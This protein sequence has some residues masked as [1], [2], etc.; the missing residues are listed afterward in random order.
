MACA[1]YTIVNVTNTIGQANFQDAVICAYAVEQG[2]TVAGFGT[3]VLLG[4]V[5]LP[6][7]IRQES[8]VIP[9]VLSMILGGI[10]L[11]STAGFVQGMTVLLVLLVFGLGPV[12]L[13][14]R[15]DRS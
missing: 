11:D 10:L 15:V 3:I 6:I 1:D 13:L 9:F 7:Y 5:N 14:R 2:L 4:A 8:A 12:L